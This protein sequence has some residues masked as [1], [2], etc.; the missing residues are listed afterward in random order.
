MQ[1]MPGQMQAPQGQPRIANQQPFYHN[2]RP[3]RIPRHKPPNNQPAM[4][5]SPPGG[6]MVQMI[7]PG[8]PQSIPSGKPAP[9]IPQHVSMRWPK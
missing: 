8:A 4:Y 3:M 5:S 1:Q 7:G 9:F 2:Q 6:P